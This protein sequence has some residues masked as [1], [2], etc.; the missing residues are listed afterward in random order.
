[1]SGEKAK[2]FE[3]PKVRFMGRT[4]LQLLDV[5]WA[6][7]PKSNVAAEVTRYILSLSKGSDLFPDE[8][9]RIE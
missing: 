8:R 5:N 4:D 7:K 9:A 1:V 6:Y 3:F 2:S